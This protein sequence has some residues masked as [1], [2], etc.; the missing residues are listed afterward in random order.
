MGLYRVLAPAAESSDIELNPSTLFLFM[1]IA[2]AVST[3][4]FA[5]FAFAEFA[6]P[7]VATA[8]AFMA[9][10]FALAFWKYSRPYGA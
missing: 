7:F 3:F 1:F 9:T 4:A 6:L 5:V 2:F 10:A 8:S